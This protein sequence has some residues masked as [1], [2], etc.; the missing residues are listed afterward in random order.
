MGCDYCPLKMWQEEVKFEK[1]NEMQGKDN[2]EVL[3]LRNQGNL[4]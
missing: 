2:F 1:E 3:V 4:D